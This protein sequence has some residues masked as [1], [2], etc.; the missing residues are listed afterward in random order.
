MRLPALAA[1]TIVSAIAT[2]TAIVSATSTASD[3]APVRADA[4]FIVAF[5]SDPKS[6]GDG[7]NTGK[8]FAG[9]AQWLFATRWALGLEGTLAQFAASDPGKNTI[10][11]TRRTSRIAIPLAWRMNPQSRVQMEIVGSVGYGH[12][13]T[14][15]ISGGPVPESGSRNDGVGWSAGLGATI[16]WVA[17][18]AFAIDLRYEALHFQGSH[19]AH[20]GIWLGLRTSSSGKH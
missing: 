11:G 20:T 12:E 7:W 14:D 3:A 19:L 16:P 15:P 17:S 5:P 9:T 2:V 18:T 4:R 10:G 6:F 13:S 8:G 1:T